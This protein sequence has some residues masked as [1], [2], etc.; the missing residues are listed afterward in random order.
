MSEN[1][2]QGKN[3]ETSGLPQERRGYRLTAAGDDPTKGDAT[4]AARRRFLIR[5]SIAGPFL[6]TLS[7]R[8]LLAESKKSKKNR[9]MK[10]SHNTSHQRKRSW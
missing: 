3:G 8:P 10:L 2:Q 5:G 1:E 4:R 6:L 9:T 7:S